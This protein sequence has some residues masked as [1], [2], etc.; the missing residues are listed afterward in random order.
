MEYCKALLTNDTPKEEYKTLMENKERLHRERMEE[1]IE[2]DDDELTLERF[3]I[4]LKQ[5]ELKNGNK[6]DKIRKSGMSY[7]LAI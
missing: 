1:V 4:A 2:D 7:K 3:F 6:Y 5:I